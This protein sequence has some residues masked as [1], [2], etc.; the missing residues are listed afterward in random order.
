[1]TLTLTTDSSTKFSSKLNW[2]VFREVPRKTF[3]WL[4]FFRCGMEYLYYRTLS[5]LRDRPT[6][7]PTDRPTDRLIDRQTEA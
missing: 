4:P 1:M 6:N 5:L 7:Q 3:D 2:L